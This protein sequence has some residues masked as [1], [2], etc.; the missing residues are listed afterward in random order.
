[1]EGLIKDFILP[2]SCLQNLKLM[3][4]I[5]YSLLTFQEWEVQTPSQDK[6]SELD[7]DLFRF[8]PEMTA[9]ITKGSEEFFRD[10]LMLDGENDSVFAEQ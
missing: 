6:N 2:R 10:L 7:D 9:S 5:I 3:S 1:M 4:K 8:Q